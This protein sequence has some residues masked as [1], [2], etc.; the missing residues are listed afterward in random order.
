[1][2]ATP[3]PST[4]PGPRVKR[5]IFVRWL[6]AV[7]VLV[8]AGLLLWSEWLGEQAARRYPPQGRFVEVAGGR[9]YYR[10]ASPSIEP[11]GTVALI[12]G[13]SSGHADL[14]ATL[15]PELRHYRVIA[16]DR[17]GQGWS[18]RL[19]GDAMA[20]PGRQAE[21]LMQALDAIAP[22]HIVLVAHSLAGAAA[23]RIALERPERL[24]GV[25][26]LGAIT[27]PWGGRGGWYQQVAALPLIGPVF[28]R[29]V[30]VPATSLLIE[31]GAKSVFAPRTVPQGYLQTGEIPLLLRPAAFR[32]NAQDV[33]ATNAFVAAQAPRY[34]ELKVPV[35]AIT[36]D[37]DAIVSPM[38]HSATIARQAPQGRFVLLPGVGHMP[39]H[40]APEII[41]EA[42]DQ[43]VGPRSGLA[44]N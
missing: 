24:R 21:A 39:H 1:M 27:H 41:V 43:I 29:L 35:V 11:R 18:D 30:G 10:E 16:I 42:I 12:H 40:A 22:E 38:R 20:D 15:G 25:V 7:A 26:L 32:A 33:A 28:V 8:P 19:A 9:L 23:L 4:K 2:A 3:E 6:I 31:A 37:S 5:G 14:L 36:G 44:S 17:P 34:G 13:A